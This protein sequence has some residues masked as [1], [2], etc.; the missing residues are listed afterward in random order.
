MFLLVPQKDIDFLFFFLF[1]Y[2]SLS[3]FSLSLLSFTHFLSLNLSLSHFPKL[4]FLDVENHRKCSLVSI[5]G[6]RKNNLYWFSRHCQCLAASIMVKWRRESERKK[7]R[8]A[9]WW[10]RDRERELKKRN[11][12]LLLCSKENSQMLFSRS[13]KEERFG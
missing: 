8:K 12:N 10:D 5:I 11:I 9:G 4:S 2:F 13:M 7:Q 1:F 6:W 3:H